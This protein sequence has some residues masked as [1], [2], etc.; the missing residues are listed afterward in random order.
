MQSLRRADAGRFQPRNEPTRR[1]RNTITRKDQDI[2]ARFGGKAFALILPHAPLARVQA[3]GERIRLGVEG[4]RVPLGVVNCRVSIS[5]GCASL[6]PL[7]GVMPAA[8]IAAADAELYCAEHAG[9]NCI[10]AV[11][12]A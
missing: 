8:L 9:R 7:E 11:V 1:R 3:V 6:V 4:L 10:R 5:V 2:L 12:V